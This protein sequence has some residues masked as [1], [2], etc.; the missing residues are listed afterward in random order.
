RQMR[1]RR[2]GFRTVIEGD[3]ERRRFLERRGGVF[4]HS[5]MGRHETSEERSL[6]EKRERERRRCEAMALTDYGTLDGEC[7]PMEAASR[8]NR[9][10][11]PPLYRRDRVTLCQQ[12]FG[13]EE[14][15][16]IS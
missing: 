3:D 6:R 13:A 5:T 11:A 1:L 14:Q 15:A 8:V 9:R 4:A 7:A 10:W 16:L 12:K 2:R